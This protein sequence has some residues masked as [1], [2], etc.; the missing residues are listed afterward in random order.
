MKM[1]VEECAQ[2]MGISGQALR[3]GIQRGRF[4]FGNCWKGSGT[5]LYYYINRADF[6][7]WE[8]G[9][10]GVGNEENEIEE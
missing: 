10:W 4:P 9:D 6:E 7:R 8:R 1:R 3:I 2:R 5:R